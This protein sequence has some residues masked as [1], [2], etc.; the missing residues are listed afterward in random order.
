M[1]R[2]IE[3]AFVGEGQALYDSIAQIPMEWNDVGYR[4]QSRWLFKESL[5]HIVGRYNEM[6]QTPLDEANKELDGRCALD[7][8][9]PDIRAVVE[10]KV[11]EL[12][13]MCRSAEQSIASY[14]PSHLYRR[15][16]TGRADHDDIGRKS[17]SNDIMAWMSL[18]L[19]RHWFAQQ[20]ALVSRSSQTT[21]CQFDT[22]K[23][24]GRE[25]QRKIW[26]LRV[27]QEDCSWRTS[28]SG[29]RVRSWLPLSLPNVVKGSGCYRESSQRHQGEH[30]GFCRG[31]NRQ[32]SALEQR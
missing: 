14:Y 32:R 5:I 19:F 16:A 12:R 31:N 6:L 30:Q 1:L 25:P 27:L 8:L 10:R 17:Y 22:D 28:V 21:Y 26:R 29:Q 9:R 23:V 3:S 13:Q 20:I 2:S 24:T 4:L 11:A 7:S 15:S 18:S